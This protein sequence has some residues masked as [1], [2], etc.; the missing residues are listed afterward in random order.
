LN[1]IYGL[2]LSLAMGLPATAVILMHNF[3]PHVHNNHAADFVRVGIVRLRF[4]LLNLLFF[5][6]VALWHYAPMKARA[7]AAW[8]KTRPHLY[9][10]VCLE[11]L[12]V[13]PLL[14]VLFILRPLDTVLYIVLPQLFGQWGILAINHVQHDGC[15]PDSA[16]N[17][18]R[19]FVGGWLNWWLLNNGFHTAHHQRPGLH[20]SRLPAL[21][22]ELSGVIDPALNRRSLAAALVEFYVWPARR[23]VLKGIGA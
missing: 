10:Q 23:P 21:H 5:P 6:L 2:M 19:N 3:N 16:C 14:L 4:N 8:R 20:W 7:L 11:R 18:S 17:H 9:R 15:D 13:Y 22:E 12:V 1:S